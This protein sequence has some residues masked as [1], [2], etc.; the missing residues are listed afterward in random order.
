[1]KIHIG[2]LLELFVNDKERIVPNMGLHGEPCVYTCPWSSI[3]C[4][5]LTVVDVSKYAPEVTSVSMHVQGGI[6]QINRI[7]LCAMQLEAP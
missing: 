7:S 2:V 1:M 4:W 6:D 3:Q 5:L